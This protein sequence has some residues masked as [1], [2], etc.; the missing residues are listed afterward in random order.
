MK[1]LETSYKV[2]M[3]LAIAVLIVLGVMLY[4]KAMRMDKVAGMKSD[5]QLLLRNVQRWYA[6]GESGQPY[7]TL[8]A[9]GKVDSAVAAMIFEHGIV[10]APF[11]ARTPAKRLVLSGKLHGIPMHY[12]KGD[13]CPDSPTIFQ[14]R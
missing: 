13:I 4:V 6:E 10:Y 1:K 11:D 2:F 12:T 7:M 14:S 8:L 9:N 5:I 3:F